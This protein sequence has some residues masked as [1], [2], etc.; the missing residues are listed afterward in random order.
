M[1]GPGEERLGVGGGGG[2]TRLIVARTNQI[3]VAQP[4]LLCVRSFRNAPEIVARGLNFSA[5]C[6]NGLLFPRWYCGR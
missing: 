6:S 2:Q 4:G 5:K 3:R 1:E